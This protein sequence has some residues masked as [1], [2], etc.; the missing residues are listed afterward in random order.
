[1]QKD[2]INAYANLIRDC[3]DAEQDDAYLCVTAK[4][5]AMPE[6]AAVVSSEPFR[7]SLDRY[8]T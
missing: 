7:R 4:R 5:L 6:K 2:I 1:M 3:L 8:S